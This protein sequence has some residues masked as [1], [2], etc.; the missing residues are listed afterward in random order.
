MIIDEQ[1][2]GSFVTSYSNDSDMETS[3]IRWAKLP[4]TPTH[5]HVKIQRRRGGRDRELRVDDDDKPPILVYST[6]TC[7]KGVYKVLDL[8]WYSDGC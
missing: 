6:Q 8:E 2:E 1:V 3:T 4:D 7:V 5:E